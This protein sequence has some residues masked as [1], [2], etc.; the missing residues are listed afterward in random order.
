MLNCIIEL[1]SVVDDRFD[2][3]YGFK[4]IAVIISYDLFKTMLRLQGLETFDC[5][6]NNRHSN[7]R[8]DIFD[9]NDN[10]MI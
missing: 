2:D 6:E 7:R 1:I 4:L 5:K 9:F 8:V 10:W 3:S